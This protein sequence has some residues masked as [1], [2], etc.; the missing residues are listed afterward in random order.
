MVNDLLIQK[1]WIEMH[2]K[3]LIR[4]I[5]FIHTIEHI[6]FR[7]LL[8]VRQLASTLQLRFCLISRFLEQLQKEVTTLIKVKGYT[9]GNKPRSIS[10]THLDLR[11]HTLVNTGHI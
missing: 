1:H 6:L 11:T 5:S 10:I 2:H 4:S 7:I 9:K 8:V 3:Y